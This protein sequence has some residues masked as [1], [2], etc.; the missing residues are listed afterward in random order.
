MELIKATYDS[1]IEE[2]KNIQKKEY[3]FV[4]ENL[5]NKIKS[6]EDIN[7]IEEIQEIIKSVVNEFKDYSN[8]NNIKMTPVLENLVK[9]LKSKLKIEAK[10]DTIISPKIT[11]NIENPISPIDNNNKLISPS[12]VV[13]L[14]I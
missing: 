6:R 12:K 1:Q 5:Y 13:I 9:S 4:I 2:L 3:K 10:D 14:K 11:S 8:K 7:T